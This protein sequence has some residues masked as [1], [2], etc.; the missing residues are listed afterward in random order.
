MRGVREVSRFHAGRAGDRDGRAIAITLRSRKR[1]AGRL[2]AR[3]GDG[4]TE[5]RW[6]VK[7]QGDLDKPQVGRLLKGRSVGRLVLTQG[8]RSYVLPVRYYAYELPDVFIN[9]PS[10][11]CVRMMRTDPLVQFE[12]D[13]V[14]GP[15]EWRT[16]VASGRFEEE[17]EHCP[18][19]TVHADGIFRIRLNCV[20]GLCRSRNGEALARTA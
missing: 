16:L 20:R 3:D 14:E 9:P 2:N 5:T 18:D 11:P 19:D 15:M 13:D 10:E 17:G 1:G 12:V 4:L 8:P 6:T 7:M